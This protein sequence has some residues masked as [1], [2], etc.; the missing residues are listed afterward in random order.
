MQRPASETSQYHCPILH[1]L[2]GLVSLVLREGRIGSPASER[3]SQHIHET[4]G[5]FLRLPPGIPGRGQDARHFVEISLHRP[6]FLIGIVLEAQIAAAVYL[7]GPY[8]KV[9][10]T[11]PS[12]IT[13]VP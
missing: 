3:S 10:Q 8:G 2:P 11:S 5:R 4:C 12:G 6:A 7:L 9:C 1:Q 13:I